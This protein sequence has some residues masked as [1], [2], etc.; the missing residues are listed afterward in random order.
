MLNATKIKMASWTRNTKVFIH[1]FVD[2][3]FIPIKKSVES[4]RGMNITYLS[5]L[6]EGRKLETRIRVNK[7]IVQPNSLLFLDPIKL[8]MTPRPQSIR[9]PIKNPPILALNIG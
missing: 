4:V 6:A 8:N 2:R 7:I 9:F 5:S 3:L 1:G